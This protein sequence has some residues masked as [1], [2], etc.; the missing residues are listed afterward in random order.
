M[1]KK[2]QNKFIY[3]QSGE[4]LVYQQLTASYE[5]GVIDLPIK[6]EEEAPQEEE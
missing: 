4:E 6:N 3:D 5:S 1:E 2:K